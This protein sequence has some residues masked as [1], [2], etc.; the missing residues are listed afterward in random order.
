VEMY[1]VLDDPIKL[2]AMAVAVAAL[3][4]V[5]IP[6]PGS[7]SL[8]AVVQCTSDLTSEL[9]SDTMNICK[10][11]FDKL[12]GSLHQCIGN[13]GSLHQSIDEDP[14]PVEKLLELSRGKPARKLW[15]K[16][17]K[18]QRAVNIPFLLQEHL[19]CGAKPSAESIQSAFAET[20]AK[21][22]TVVVTNMAIQALWRPLK[23]EEN[24]AA[25]S[26]LALREKAKLDAQISPRIALALQ[27][28]VQEKKKDDKNA[29]EQ[30][31]G[32]KKRGSEDMPLS[33]HP[34]KGAKSRA[35]SPEAK[36]QR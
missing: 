30:A 22:K 17:Q 1:D 13:F 23:E 33:A 35:E 16:W 28:N 15:S 2:K 5:T 7:D 32:S 3:Q 29:T 6:D 12:E 36:G 8:K 20:M 24:R 11:Q 34:R 14:I 26:E 10:A 4:Q 21:V 19:G 31:S 18:L 25:L 27:K 9:V